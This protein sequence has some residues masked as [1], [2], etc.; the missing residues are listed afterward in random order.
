M[1]VRELR[2]FVAWANEAPDNATFW[3]RLWFGAASYDARLCALIRGMVAQFGI[4]PGLLQRQD[5]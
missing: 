2:M 1:T 4:V 3:R 5:P